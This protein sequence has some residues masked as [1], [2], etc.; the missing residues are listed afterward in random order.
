MSRDTLTLTKTTGGRNLTMLEATPSTTRT[1]ATGATAATRRAE[2]RSPTGT[3]GKTIIK[4][5][6]IMTALGTGRKTMAS[7]EDLK[8]ISVSMLRHLATTTSVPTTVRGRSTKMVAR[9]KE[10]IKVEV[11]TK[12]EV[13]EAGAT[14]GLSTTLE[15]VIVVDLV[16]SP[17]NLWLLPASRGSKLRNAKSMF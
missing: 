9:G 14:I 10:D 7:P 6:N 12:A 2:R 8:T 4:I 11:V 5:G 1:R 17:S 3:T 15:E 16:T 13:T